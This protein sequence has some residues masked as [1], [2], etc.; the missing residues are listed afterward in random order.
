MKLL[1][2]SAKFHKLVTQVY[3]TMHKYTWYNTLVTHDMAYKIWGEWRF[4]RFIHSIITV[5]LGQQKQI[6][7]NILLT[8]SPISNDLHWPAN[9]RIC[10]LIK[11]EFLISRWGSRQMYN[12]YRIWIPEVT[13][14]KNRLSHILQRNENK[15]NIWNR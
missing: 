1:N 13:L 6:S 10:S 2:F 7:N 8:T 15:L 5:D 11:T 14:V 3:I 9:N 4:P 12:K